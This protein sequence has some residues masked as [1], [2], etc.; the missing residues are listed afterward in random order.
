MEKWENRTSLRATL[1]TAAFRFIKFYR[2]PLI[3]KEFS[4]IFRTFWA[5]EENKSAFLGQKHQLRIWMAEAP[6]TAI[7]LFFQEKGSFALS[8]FRFARRNEANKL[9]SAI[10][11][12]FYQVQALCHAQQFQFLNNLKPTILEQ[13]H[14]VYIFWQICHHESPDFKRIQSWGPSNPDPSGNNLRDIF[15]D[16]TSYFTQFVVFFWQPFIGDTPKKS[17]SLFV[18]V[19]FWLAKISVIRVQSYG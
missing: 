19:P 16:R 10:S 14:A 8:R 13:K 17:P 12:A 18:I 15:T 3:R 6:A 9:V 7:R 11:A 4:D 2:Q 5:F 1:P